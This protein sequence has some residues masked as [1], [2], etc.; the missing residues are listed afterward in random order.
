MDS[1]Q[2]RRVAGLMLFMLGGLAGTALALRWSRGRADMAG[3]EIR[4]FAGRIQGVRSA[5]DETVETVE[6]SVGY[7]RRLAGPVHEVLE[8]M[9]A[10][11]AGIHRTMDSYRSI[12]GSSSAPDTYVP[13]MAPELRR[14]SVEPS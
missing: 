6:S 4:T 8:E 11:A 2:D 12:G 3:G 14:P 1:D 13:S 9:G 5:L 7:L 10:L